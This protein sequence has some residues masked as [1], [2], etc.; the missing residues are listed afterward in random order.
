MRRRVGIGLIGSPTLLNYVT[1]LTSVTADASVFSSGNPEN[2]W[3]FATS[4]SNGGGG[5]NGIVTVEAGGLT[6]TG[7]TNEVQEGAVMGCQFAG[8]PQKAYFQTCAPTYPGVVSFTFATQ[9]F[10]QAMFNS[11]Q[12]GYGLRGISGVDGSSF[13]CDDDTTAGLAPCLPPTETVPEPITMILFG[14]GLLGVGG[15]AARKRRREGI[16]TV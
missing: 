15:A 10:T 13:K 7:N 9:N 11:T 2:H 6:T 5:G 3:T 8:S 14:S 16:E 12:F 4:L 1:G